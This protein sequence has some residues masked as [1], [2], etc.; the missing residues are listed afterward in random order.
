[1][2]KIQ[3]LI[4]KVFT[5]C[6]GYTPLKQRKDDIFKE[7]WELLKAD[8]IPHTREELGDLLSSAI[9]MANENNWSV[10]ELINENLNKILKRKKQY[11]STGRRPNIAIWGGSFD[12]IHIG[13]E[14]SAEVVLNLSKEIDEVWFTPSYKSLYGK[15]LVSP[16]DRLNMCELIAKRDGRFKVFPYEIEN[17][18]SGETYH[19]LK[20]LTN[21]VAYQNYRF[22]F[23]IGSDTALTLP[24]WPNSKYLM[25]LIPFIIIHRPE[26][27]ISKD[28]WFLKRP[29]CIYIEPECDTN[30]NSTEIRNMIKNSKG[31]GVYNLGEYIRDEI[32]EY[33]FERGLYV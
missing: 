2:K 27:N 10:E 25:N 28:A 11:Q 9:Q 13:H 21:D 30:V 29:D 17:K 19:F 1:M 24:N 7:A 32:L 12:P 22:H 4:K 23:M 20:R 18:L 3:D 8:S 33:I 31:K 5:E 16:Q 15:N 14:K 26:T 6:F